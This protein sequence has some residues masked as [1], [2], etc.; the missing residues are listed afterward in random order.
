MHEASTAVNY[1]PEANHDYDCK[2]LGKK[3]ICV[4]NTTP[5][6]SSITS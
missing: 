3:R 6:G 4:N 5:R 2:H 1:L